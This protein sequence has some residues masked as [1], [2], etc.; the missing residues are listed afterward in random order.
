MR[1]GQR[2]SL[3]ARFAPKATESLRRREMTRCATN[4]HWV[5]ALMKL[6]SFGPK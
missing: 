1:F 4:G 2:G 3:N 5:Q 6:G